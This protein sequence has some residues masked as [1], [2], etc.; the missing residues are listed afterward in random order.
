[1]KHE[2]GRVYWRN[3]SKGYS[4]YLIEGH[5]T[6]DGVDGVLVRRPWWPSDKDHIFWCP[7]AEVS[8]EE[9][10]ADTKWTPDN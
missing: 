1:M 10:E 4:P 3:G 7:V 9:V 6:R 8:F 2:I 5:E